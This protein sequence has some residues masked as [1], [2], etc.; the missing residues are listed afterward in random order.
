[1]KGNFWKLGKWALLLFILVAF[2]Y[3]ARDDFFIHLAIVIE[4]WVIL[5][6]SLNLI[7]GYTGQVSFCH[8]AF[9][10]IGAYTSALLTLR[11]GFSFW[12]ALP[13]GAISAGFLALLIGLPSFRVRG[14]YFSIITM[15]FGE[16]VQ[17]IFHNW[18]G[19]TNGPDG[20]P[21]IPPPPTIPLPLL[22]NFV[23]S[24]KTSFYYLSLIAALAT[25]LI[26]R[27]LVQS[28]VG[29]A[30]VAIR[31]DEGYARSV[32]IDPMTYK[33]LSFVIG[34]IFAGMAGCLYAHYFLYISPASFTIFQSFDILLMVIIGGMGSIL[35]PIFGA[36]FLT[37]M[38]EYLHL[39]NEY[40]MV[41]YGLL[42]V[43]VII[44]APQGLVGAAQ[45]IRTGLFAGR[46]RR[47]PQ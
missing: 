21:G 29:R 9:Y 14:A 25:V 47:G 42:L 43:V 44:L 37:S 39:A 45:S 13:L 12:S 17:I 31:E 15:A 6:L 11:M 36:I 19:L 10:G 2:P 41:I 7:V 22:S 27:R 33:L 23:F 8:A 18:R 32:G 38:P 40:R 24:E 28:R 3:L 30:F 35:G 26:L 5:V 1:M 34:A 16:L 20:L 4:I 46:E